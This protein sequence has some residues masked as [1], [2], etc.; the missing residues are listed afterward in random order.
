MFQ[1]GQRV[2]LKD[3]DGPFMNVSYIYTPGIA[4]NLQLEV[5]LYAT[6]WIDNK[7]NKK[8]GTFPEYVLEAV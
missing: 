4:P 7:Q 2:K 1:L 3:S 8:E 6:V 5:D